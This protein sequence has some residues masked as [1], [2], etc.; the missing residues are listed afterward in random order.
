[1]AWGAQTA[2]RA[3]LNELSSGLRCFFILLLQVSF[4]PL[5]YASTDT[6]KLLHYPVLVVPGPNINKKEIGLGVFLGSPCTLYLLTA[7]HVLVNDKNELV[8]NA[9]QI[10]GKFPNQNETEKGTG[11]ETEKGTGRF[12]WTTGVA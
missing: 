7:R 6:N 9:A 8:K 5:L 4:Q 1:M 3:H 2:Q 12:F 11:S 10:H